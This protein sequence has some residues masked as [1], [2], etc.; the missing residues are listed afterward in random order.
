LNNQN[1]N[2]K[3]S[4]PTI[5]IGRKK[6]VVTDYVLRTLGGDDAARKED[7]FQ[8]F[9]ELRA[10]AAELDRKVALWHSAPG[11]AAFKGVGLAKFLGLTPEAYTLWVQGPMQMSQAEDGA[12][13]VARIRPVGP[14]QTQA[15]RVRGGGNEGRQ[16]KSDRM[17]LTRR[18]ETWL[19]PVGV[20]RRDAE[21]V[22]RFL[23]RMEAGDPPNANSLKPLLLGIAHAWE[24]RGP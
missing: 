3:T 14:L 7:L 10:W 4:M 2:S 24:G 11:S 21:A 9:P 23:A 18:R 5:T 12:L 8:E 16:G 6:T 22:K 19:L 1:Q 13:T 20:N 15:K 17:D